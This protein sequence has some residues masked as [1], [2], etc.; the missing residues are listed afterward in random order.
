MKVPYQDRL[1][2]PSQPGDGYLVPKGLWNCHDFDS[3]A[4]PRKMC[5]HDVDGR[6]RAN[7]RTGEEVRLDPQDELLVVHVDHGV[8]ETVVRLIDVHTK[9]WLR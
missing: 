2:Y 7:G 4:P 6:L 9:H 8:P 1:A 5:D 3:R